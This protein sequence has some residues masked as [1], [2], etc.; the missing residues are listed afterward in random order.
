M[1]AR[2][3]PSAGRCIESLHT[4]GPKAVDNSYPVVVLQLMSDSLS[5]N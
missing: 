2:M 5:D 4:A 1:Y 3:Y